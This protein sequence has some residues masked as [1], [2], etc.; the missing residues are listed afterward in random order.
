MPRP[1]I[2]I[3][4]HS[5]LGRPL[6]NASKLHRVSL[7]P[8]RNTVSC[9]AN[10]A[11]AARE[12]CANGWLCC[13][14][15][16]NARVLASNQC[17]IMQSIGRGPCEGSFLFMWDIVCFVRMEKKYLWPHQQIEVLPMTTTAVHVSCP[18]FGARCLALHNLTASGCL[19]CASNLTC[20][21]SA[22]LTGTLTLRS[23]QYSERAMAT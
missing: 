14:L 19:Q 22:D 23:S 7:I 17:V 11:R 21:P 13:P 2:A 15:D 20:S 18:V 4:I 3:L 8:H 16:S 12:S 1:L 5:V 6:P 9:S 10:G